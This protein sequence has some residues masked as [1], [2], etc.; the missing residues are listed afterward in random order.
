MP[1]DA[2][3]SP[4]QTVEC[5]WQV[6]PDKYRSNRPVL[7]IYWTADGYNTTGN[8][9]LDKSAFVQTNRAWAFGGALSPVSVFGGQQ[10]ELEMTFYL[11]QGNW[12]L[13]LKGTTAAHA[14]GYYP[15]S[16]FGTGPLARAATTIDY[17]GETVGSGSW[18]PMGSGSFASAGWQRA[19][20]QRDVY[21]FPPTGGALQASL[22]NAQPSPRCYTVSNLSATAPW[23]KY[24]F[25][26]GPGGS[27]CE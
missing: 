12:W 26:G 15:A 19:A 20:Y 7:F 21:Y 16:L 14:V 2:A 25:F 8:Y 22:S 24:F 1:C 5:G 4:V 6:Y 10:Y 27:R 9:N 17:G 3:G 13:Y 11:F 23:N 18:P